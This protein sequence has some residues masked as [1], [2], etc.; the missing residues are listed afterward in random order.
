[1]D[2]DD[3]EEEAG[4]VGVRIAQHPA[5][6][7]VAHDMLGRIEGDQR[8]GRVVH[9]HDDAGD[10]LDDQS[11]AGEHAEIPEIVEVARHGIAAADGAVDQS[12]ERQA[13]IQPFGQIG[14]R[15]VVLGPGKAHLLCSSTDL[16]DS[17]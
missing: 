3:D 7:H 12:G 17:I 4:A 1:M 10:D 2:I 5:P 14:L 11:D 13:L 9:R 8:V 16:D 6:V 15:F